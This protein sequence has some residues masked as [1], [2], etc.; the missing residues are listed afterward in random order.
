MFSLPDFT[1]SF[2]VFPIYIWSIH[3]NYDLLVFMELSV[4][5]SPS[6]A[7]LFKG[8]LLLSEDGGPCG[9]GPT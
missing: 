8:L 6:N 7:I 1:S 9:A 5:V 3:I 4:C 2:V